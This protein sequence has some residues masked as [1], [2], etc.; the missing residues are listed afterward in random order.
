LADVLDAEVQAGRGVRS[1]LLDL[2]GLNYA[3]STGIGALITSTQRLRCVGVD[4]ILVDTPPHIQHIVDLLGFSP[5]L[6]FR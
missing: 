4:L 5:S 2:A 1:L 6:D 3:S